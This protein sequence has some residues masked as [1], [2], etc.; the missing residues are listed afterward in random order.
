MNRPIAGLLLSLAAMALA[1]LAHAQA[2]R[3]WVS[4]VGDDV[5]PCSRTAPCK[6][7]AGAISKTAVNGYINALDPAGFGAVTITKSITLDGTGTMAGILSAGTNG[8]IVSGAG[9]KVVLRGLSIE[10]F[11]TGLNGIRILNASQVSIEDTVIKGYTGRGISVEA[12]APIELLVKDTNITG[13]NVGA[14]LSNTSGQLLA[15]FDNVRI[16]NMTTHGIDTAGTSSVFAVVK[17][18][19]IN[20]N[21]Q[22]GV[23]AGTAATQINLL[24]STL[25]F[26]NG[27][28]VNAAVS[29]SRIRMSGNGI[30]NNNIALGIAAGATIES[31]GNN[32]IAGFGSTVSPNA[33]LNMQ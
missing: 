26:N 17:N 15:T 12:A 9:I 32:A 14:F 18:S 8:I 21:N 28:S 31:A 2:S 19:V 4:G 6:T 11:S 33:G 1:P 13:A 23:R 16:E 24:N 30:F 22:D 29:G 27:T 5:N 3:T 20:N 10:G 25:S 7:W